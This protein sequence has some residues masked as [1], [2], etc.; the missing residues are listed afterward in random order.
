MVGT[1]AQ[2][3]ESTSENKTR[4]DP[5]RRGRAAVA[6]PEAF[7]AILDEYTTALQSAPLSDQTRRTYT[8]KVRQFLAWLADTDRPASATRADLPVRAPKAL[9]KRAAVRFLRVYGKGARARSGSIP[10]C[11]KR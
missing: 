3:P 6:L 1:P 2:D 7:S 4:R 9:S 5:P 10:S 11:A 8:S